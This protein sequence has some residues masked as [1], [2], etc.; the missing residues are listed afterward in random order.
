MLVIGSGA[1]GA[2]VASVFNAFGSRVSLFEA[3]ERILR[4]EE[5]EVSACV[6]AAF[7]AAGVVIH[8]RFGAIEASR[9]SPAACAWSTARRPAMSAE[10]ELAVLAIGWTAA[11]AALNLTAA[12]VALDCARLRHGRRPPADQRAARL[13]R[14]RRDRP[15]DAD[16]RGAAGGDGRGHERGDGR[17][18]AGPSPAA[19]PVGSFTDPEYAQVGLGEAQARQAH[20]VE[21]V[22][23]DFAE[24]TRAVIDGRTTGFCKL[25]VDRV[26]QGS[27]RLPH[28]GRAGGGGGA[29]GRGGDR[30][31]R[32]GRRSGAPAVLVPTYAGILARAAAIAAHRLNRGGAA[33]PLGPAGLL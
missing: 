31:G 23:V 3:G 1:T 9:P 5:P 33:S 15:E 13:R 26:T 18:R 7:R 2:Q 11:T 22:S 6:A 27:P 32:T 4:T 16:A 30:R 12:G 14:R 19:V 17:Q 25:I 24:N 20:E 10:A 29:T 28:R 8:E 21:V